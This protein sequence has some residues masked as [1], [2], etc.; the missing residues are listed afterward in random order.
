MDRTLALENKTKKNDFQDVNILQQTAFE[1]FMVTKIQK[2]HTDVFCTMVPCSLAGGY[3][4][5]RATCCLHLEGD[6]LPPQR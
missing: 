1:V 3:Q 6:I 2:I 4:F 5:F